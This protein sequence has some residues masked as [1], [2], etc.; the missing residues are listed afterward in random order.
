MYIGMVIGGVRPIVWMGSS[1]IDLRQFPARVR[2]DIGKALYAAQHGVT[3]PAVKPLN[4]D[5]IRVARRL[6]MI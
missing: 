6:K 4:C 5:S 2:G 1:R 3:D